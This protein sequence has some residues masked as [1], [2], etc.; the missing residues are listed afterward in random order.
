MGADDVDTGL[1][2]GFHLVGCVGVCH[3]ENVSAA[4]FFNQLDFFW[5]P[6]T[7]CVDAVAEPAVICAGRGHVCDA[8]KTNVHHLTD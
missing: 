1:D 2:H 4:A 5:I 6:N 3:G 7:R 8:A